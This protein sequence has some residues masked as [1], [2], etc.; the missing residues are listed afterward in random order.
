[1]LMINQLVNKPSR[2]N[3]NL[4]AA[5]ELSVAGGL[6]DDSHRVL[7]LSASRPI[8]PLWSELGH[9]NLYLSKPTGIVNHFSRPEIDAS[10]SMRCKSIR[11]D[12]HEEDAD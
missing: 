9:G 12:T 4:I 2:P 1:M 7:T 11:E 8:E 5:M 6:T 3:R 10:H